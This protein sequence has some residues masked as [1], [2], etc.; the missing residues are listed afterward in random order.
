MS[1]DWTRRHFLNTSLAGV[2]APALIKSIQAAPAVTQSLSDPERATLKA[3]VDEIIPAGH[4]MPSAS[5]VGGVRYLESLIAK[6][7]GMGQVLEGCVA[8]LNNSGFA[9]L[10][11]TERIAALE[12]LEKESPANFALLRDS[13]YESYYTNPQVWK[14]IGYDLYPTD[15]TGPHMKPFDKSVIASV[16]QKPRYYREA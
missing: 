12:K 7:P 4:G 10:S 1:A 13:V 16:S 8:A 2:A 11:Q 9:H 5:E 14:L 6:E 15:H 3:I